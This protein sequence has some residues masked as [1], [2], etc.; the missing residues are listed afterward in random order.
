[1]TQMKTVQVIYSFTLLYA[2][3]IQTHATFIHASQAPF[4]LISKVTVSIVGGILVQLYKS[5][6]LR[7]GFNHTH[8]TLRQIGQARYYAP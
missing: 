6:Q 7:T 4:E 8:L 3:K 5:T 2:C 1:M